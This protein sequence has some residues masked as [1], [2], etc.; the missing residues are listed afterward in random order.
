[1]LFAL[2]GFTPASVAQRSSAKVRLAAAQG[3]TV[4][5]PAVSPTQAGLHIIT[6]PAGGTAVQ[7]GGALAAALTKIGTSATQQQPYLVFLDAGSFTLGESFPTI[8]PFVS[9]RGAGMYS[10]M[11]EGTFTFSGPVGQAMSFT[12]S[13][14]SIQ[15]PDAS[16]VAD[17]VGSV[18]I[19][20]VFTDAVMSLQNNF[21]NANVMI[22]NSIF[23]GGVALR[24]TTSSV[25][26]TLVGSQVS[27]FQPHGS[28]GLLCLASYNSN[29]VSV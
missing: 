10:T 17:D 14:M 12:L 23:S 24:S 28:A 9:L 13:D 29:F 20:N 16:I 19:D 21:G 8:Q 7:N 27:G 11:V 26:F 4:A 3:L 1:M 22:R 6:I 5:Q 15:G 2:L 18:L 25:H